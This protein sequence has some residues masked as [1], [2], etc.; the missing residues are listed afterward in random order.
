MIALT[1]LC[2]WD[3]EGV[4]LTSCLRV[5]GRRAPDLANRLGR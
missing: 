5:T 3:R 2:A 4:G 1:D